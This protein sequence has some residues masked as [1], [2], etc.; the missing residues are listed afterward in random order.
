VTHRP[1]SLLASLYDRIMADVDYEA[2]CE[3]ILGEA[4]KRGFREG[5]VLDLGC[6]TG[7][8]S[9]P[10]ACRGLTVTGLDGSAEMLEVA[11]GKK[12]AIDWQQADFTTF[13]LERRY[14][15]AI[16]VFDSLNNLLTPHQFLSCAER[17]YAHLLPGGLF[18]FDVNTTA[19]LRDLWEDGRVEGWTDD[20]YY[21]WTHA[22]DPVTGLARVE[23]HCREGARSFTE[24]HL[25]RPYDADEVEVLLTAAGFSQVEALTFPDGEPAEADAERI[26]VC[27]R[28]PVALP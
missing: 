6:G 27:A 1:F 28:R 3:F 25:E 13:S 22:F 16:A 10:L 14:E 23:A 26:W 9:I 21:R 18:L 5:A 17:V 4:G 15:L 24:V 8:S 11:R 19:G 2:W 12:P 20:L 7:N